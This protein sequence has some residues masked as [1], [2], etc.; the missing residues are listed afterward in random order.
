NTLAGAIGNAGSGVTT[1]AKNDSGTWVLT[2]NH[3]YT[4]STNINAGTLLIGDGGTTGSI[5]SSLLNNFGTLGF[6]RAD[7]LTYGGSIVGTGAVSQT[8]AGTTILTGNNSYTG[9]TTVSAGAL[10]INGD[11]SAA[12]GPTAVQ[13][14]ATLGGVGTVGGDVAVVG[15]T[16]APGNSPGTLTIVGDLVL[17]AASILD[18]EFGESDVVGGPLNDLIDVGGDLALDG[19]INVAVSAGGSFDAGLYRVI[20]YGGGFTDNGLDLGTMPT[21][22]DVFV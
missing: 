17:D 5:T 12:T 7:T 1:L 2:G 9:A 21:G 14:G 19:T 18:F 22:R 6:D 10:W 11:Q 20:N 16:L 13:V 8:G 4:G 15:G 3:T